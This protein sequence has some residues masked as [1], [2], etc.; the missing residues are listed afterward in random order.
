MWTNKF[1]NLGGLQLLDIHIVLLKQGVLQCARARN[2]G[3]M[4][5]YRAGRGPAGSVGSLRDQHQLRWTKEGCLQI[6]Y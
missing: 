5:L 2:R 1:I 6:R 4:E 3:W